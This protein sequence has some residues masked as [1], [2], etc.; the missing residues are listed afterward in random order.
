MENRAA[1]NRLLA[2][3]T[4]EELER[5]RPHAE[6]VALRYG[7]VLFDYEE[8]VGFA[9]F[10]LDCV[11]SLLSVLEDGRSIEIA[12]VGREGM[13]GLPTFLGADVSFYSGVVQVPGAALRVRSH[14]IR[15]MFGQVGPLGRQLLLHTRSLLAQVSRLA[16]CNRYHRDRRRVSRWLLM[17]HDRTGADEIRLPHEHISLR[18]GMRRSGVTDVINALK[19]EEIIETGRS[20]IRVL[21]RP[22]LEERACECYWSITEEARRAFAV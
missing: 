14:I 2:A 10:P 9:Y 20:L 19:K 1:E 8:R 3:L 11:I 6:V 21:D 18:L 22:A 12:M 13:A 15:E 5:L 7:Q 17:I 16:A 4:S